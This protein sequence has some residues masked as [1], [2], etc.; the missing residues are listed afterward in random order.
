M[1]PRYAYA[2]VLMPMC[3]CM[4]MRPSASPQLPRPHRPC[5]YRNAMHTCRAYL[6][7]LCVARVSI[8]VLCAALYMSVDTGMG[9]DSYTATMMELFEVAQ[10]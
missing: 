6:Q 8:W 4:A 5:Y 3:L 2:H 10:V 1:W 7:W 9:M